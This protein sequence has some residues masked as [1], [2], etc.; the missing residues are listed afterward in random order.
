MLLIGDDFQFRND[1]KD[2]KIIN[3]LCELF[4][5]HSEEVLGVRI[6]PILA[7]PRDYFSALE[8]KVKLH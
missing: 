4:E 1:S 2:F 6:N 8:N 5:Y 7:T 3:M